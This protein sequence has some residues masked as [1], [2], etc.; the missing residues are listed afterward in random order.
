MFSLLPLLLFLGLYRPGL[1]H[2]SLPLGTPVIT[3][4]YFE[5]FIIPL[6]LNRNCF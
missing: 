1:L 2:H 5:Q 4:D 3:D 6:A